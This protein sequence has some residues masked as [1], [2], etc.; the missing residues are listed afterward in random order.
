[1][2]REAPHPQTFHLVPNSQPAME[3]TGRTENEAF[4]SRCLNV[5][6]D[7]A[8]KDGQKVYGVEIG[9][10]VSARS[11]PQVIAR[12]GRD[13]DIILPASSISAVQ[14]S[15]EVH[16]ESRAIIFLDKGRTQTSIESDG[17]R[18]D[19]DFRQAVV[20]PGTGYVIEADSVKQRYVF[21]LIWNG[22]DDLLKSHEEQDGYETSEAR[23][24][25]SRCAQTVD[26]DGSEIRSFYA[27]RAHIPTKGVVTRTNDEKILDSGNIASGGLIAIKQITLLN[28][29]LTTP[30][31]LRHEIKNLSCLSHANVMEYLGSSSSV[32]NTIPSYMPL[33]AGN[34]SDF[35]Q[36]F[37]KLRSDQTTMIRL[38]RHMLCALDYLA[39]QRLIHRDVNPANILYHEHKFQLADFGFVNH[40][41]LAASVC[42]SLLY[43]APEAFYRTHAQSP[44]MDVW[45]LFVTIADILHAGGFDER[46]CNTYEDILGSVRAAAATLPGLSPMA[47]ENPKMRTSAAQMLVKFFNGEGL[48]TARSQIAP[49]SEP[50][51]APKA[52]QASKRYLRRKRSGVAKRK[53]REPKPFALHRRL[54]L[55]PRGDFDTVVHS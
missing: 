9:Y 42:G 52:P 40:Q 53:P 20:V 47:R 43:M 15:F 18:T 4:V 22:K 25:N 5:E 33:K 14:F 28:N 27:T 50:E 44:K 2:P 46:V 39:S 38:S 19:G 7:K 35:F 29:S 48:S 36:K 31:M 51:D 45:S 23:V 3:A 8:D 32:P 54:V 55:M 26:D 6:A 37:P 17:F 24:Q 16:P 12:V 13:A 49:I 41:N 10:Q 21:D 1:M 30:K 11:F 34:V